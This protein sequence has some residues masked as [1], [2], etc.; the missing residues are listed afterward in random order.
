MLF[1]EKLIPTEDCSLCE[2]QDIC[3][4]GYVSI[5]SYSVVTCEAFKN[6]VKEY[7]GKEKIL[8]EIDNLIKE[9]VLYKEEKQDVNKPFSYELLHSEQERINIR[10]I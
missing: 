1:N 9:A 5:P 2:L 3:N 7:G 8:E 6:A 4:V 10:R